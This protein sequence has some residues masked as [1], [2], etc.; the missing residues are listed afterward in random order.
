MAQ[1]PSER[2]ADRSRL[3]EIINARSFQEGPAI[4]LASGKTSTFY[5]NMKPTM[6]DSEGAFLIASLILD[7]LEGVDADLVGGLE[8]GA[9]PIASAVAAVAHTRRR[10]LPAFFVRK[11]A[12]EHGTRALVEGLAEGDSMA[13]KKVV[14]VEDV[15]T[16]GGSALKAAEA[17]KSEGATIVRV[18]TVV[19]RLDGAAE[20]FKSAGLDF[21]PLLTLADFRS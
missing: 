1:N 4:K 16:T 7:Q 3:V 14:V 12:K 19:D 20:T 2:S 18:I 11:Q 10:N 15:T 21:V 17:L 8:M 6:L 13:G 5:F 9:V